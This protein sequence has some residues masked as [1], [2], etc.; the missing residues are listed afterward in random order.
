MEK[1]NSYLLN[2]VIAAAA[3]TTTLFFLSKYMNKKKTDCGCTDK[4]PGSPLND[5]S[6]PD[7]GG[8]KQTFVPMVETVLP[9]PCLFPDG[10]L[11]KYDNGYAQPEWGE[12]NPD[13]PDIAGNNF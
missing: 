3:I 13:A 11:V 5:T 7:M 6:M 10:M 1:N 4:K 2:L 8:P 12:L 9:E